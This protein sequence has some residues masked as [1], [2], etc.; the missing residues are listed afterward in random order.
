MRIIIPFLGVTCVLGIPAA[1][2]QTLDDAVRLAKPD[3]I[4]FITDVDGRTVKGQLVSISPASLSILTPIA[5]VIPSERVSRIDKIGDPIRDG[6]RRGAIAGAL[7]GAV[8][9]SATLERKDWILFFPKV[10][11]GAIELGLFGMLFD[12][13]HKGRTTLYRASPGSLSIAPLAARGSHGL[14]VAWRF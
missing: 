5:V 13:L 11:T 2:A 4:V 8:N 9:A 10:W 6:F 12:W 3:D 14:A 7:F 1:S